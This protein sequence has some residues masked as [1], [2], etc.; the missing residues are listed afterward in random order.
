MKPVEPVVDVTGPF[1]LKMGEF[2]L[3]S[4]KP[5]W[6]YSPTYGEVTNNPAMLHRLMTVYVRWLARPASG[7]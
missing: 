7:Q 2:V 4:F 1:D 6:I 5:G 3:L